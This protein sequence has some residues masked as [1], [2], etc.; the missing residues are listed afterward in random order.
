M[1][2]SA[3]F[4]IAVIIIGVANT[5]GSIA[6]LNWFARCAG[7][8]RSVKVPFAPSGIGRMRYHR[9]SAGEDHPGL[10]TLAYRDARSTSHD[11]SAPVSPFVPSPSRS[12][13]YPTSASL[14]AELGQARV[15]CGRGRN[16]ATA[17]AVLGANAQQS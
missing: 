16:N 5:G 10:G 13:I 7:V 12:R 11:Q 3:A 15:Q 8:T 9:C 4:S 14:S 17:L 6:S 1:A 2:L